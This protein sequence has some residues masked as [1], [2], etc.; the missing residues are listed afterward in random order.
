MVS[1]TQCWL[2]NGFDVIVERERIF[3]IVEDV[4]GA[5]FQFNK[6]APYMIRLF[7][8]SNFL[9]ASDWQLSLLHSS[10]FHRVFRI[11]QGQTRALLGPRFQG[12]GVHNLIFVPAS[13]PFFMEPGVGLQGQALLCEPKFMPDMPAD[14]LIMRMRELNEQSEAATLFDALNRETREARALQD[15]ALQAHTSLLSIW[16]RRQ[17]ESSDAQS[18]SSTASDRLISA[19]LHLLETSYADGTSMA[20]YADQLKVTP[21]H[22]SRVCKAQLGK[23]AAD[24]IADRTL[25]AARTALETTNVP[26]KDIAQDLGFGSAAYFSRFILTHSGQSPRMLRAAARERALMAG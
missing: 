9:Q 21:T 3:A 1:K 7:P 6:E 5:I 18:V 16:M 14:A 25:H 15:I 19:F 13:Q 22:L 11:T 24:L 8:L 26:A 23:S 2:A 20:G 12:V 17:A 10:P 4:V